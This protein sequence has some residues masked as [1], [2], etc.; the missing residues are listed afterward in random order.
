MRYILGTS[1]LLVLGT[2]MLLAIL[3]NGMTATTAHAITCTDREQVCFAY[4]D[5]HNPGPRCKPV[6]RELLN[7]CMSTGCWESKI[8]AKRCGISRQ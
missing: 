6:C 2:S 4:C 5:L 7:K 3:I 8:T 1:M